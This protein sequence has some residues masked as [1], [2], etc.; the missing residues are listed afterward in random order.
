MKNITVDVR[1]LERAFGFD[2][3]EFEPGKTY[4]LA[5]LLKALGFLSP[6][7]PKTGPRATQQRVQ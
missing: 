4:P 2:L 5:Q 6:G 1:L 3:H 7:I